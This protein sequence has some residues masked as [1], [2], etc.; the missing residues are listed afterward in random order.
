MALG[1]RAVERT[2]TVCGRCTVCVVCG[3]RWYC[4][5]AL[6]LALVLVGR[7]AHPHAQVHMAMVTRTMSDEYNDITNGYSDMNKLINIILGVGQRN[8]RLLLPYIPP[9]GGNL[10]LYSYSYKVIYIHYY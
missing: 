7:W 3:G 8:I 10:K 2:C 5:L 9:T 6:V 4:V 1:E